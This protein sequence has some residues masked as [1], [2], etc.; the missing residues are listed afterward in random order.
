MVAL[1]KKKTAIKYKFKPGDTLLAYPQYHYEY[2]DEYVILY[3]TKTLYKMVAE[4][5]DGLYFSQGKISVVDQMFYVKDGAEQPLLPKFKPGDKICGR[6]QGVFTSGKIVSIGF[7]NTDVCYSI[8]WKGEPDLESWKCKAIDSIY[9]RWY[10]TE[11][12]FMRI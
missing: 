9:V 6:P 3:L 12:T 4:N 5:K 7:Y 10:S 2:P 1:M 8:K 11:G